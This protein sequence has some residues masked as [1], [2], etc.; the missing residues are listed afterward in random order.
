MTQEGPRI[1][2]TVG[3]K[4]WPFPI[5]LV[6]K[7]DQWIFDTI[8]GKEEIL[9][10]RIGENELSTVQTLLAVVDAQRE[11]ARNDSNRN[12]IREYA[13][14]FMSDAGKKNGLYWETKPGE[15]PSP[16]GELVAEARAEGYG[17]TGSKHSR[18]PFHG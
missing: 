17:G 1:V 5:P 4:D 8:A 11:Y 13:Q 14:K 12:G 6:K 15:E 7:G 9:D 2:L 10:R 3:E 16:L 18:I